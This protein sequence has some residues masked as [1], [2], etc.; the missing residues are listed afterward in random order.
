MAPSRN[1]SKCNECSKYVTNKTGGIQCQG[2]CGF[3]FHFECAGKSKS[4]YRFN[5]GEKS[6][7]TCSKCDKD[8]EEVTAVTE[9]KACHIGNSDND[10][11][12]Q[13][14]L[15]IKILT[16]QI[17]EISKNQCD[18]RNQ[19]TQLQNENAILIEALVTFERNQVSCADKLKPNAVK[20]NI[21]S[22]SMSLNDSIGSNLSNG[23]LRPDNSLVLTSAV[24]NLPS[25][26]NNGSEGD[27]QIP[28][29]TAVYLMS[30]SKFTKRSV[31][32]K[33][34]TKKKSTPQ[35]K[36]ASSA[37]VLEGKKS[38][39]S[40][41]TGSTDVKGKPRAGFVEV[42]YKK[43]KQPRLSGFIIGRTNSDDKLKVVDKLRYLFVSRI[44]EQVDSDSLK[45]YINKQVEGNFEITKLRSK[46]PGYSSYK[47]GVPISLWE[48]IFSPDF[49]PSGAF[50]NRFRYN[51]KNFSSGSD[52]SHSFLEQGD[53]TDPRS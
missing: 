5:T 39:F 25:D 34:T 18:M 48:K 43:R 6:N 4:E 7:F 35:Q 42:R 53:Q 16:D 47:V 9:S 17:Y 11:C 45:Q 8:P 36:P 3:W 32:K 50:V 52:F 37:L 23:R 41:E 26:G 29:T 46:R 38:R 20:Q 10:D 12:S 33:S 40:S 30:D 51:R 27:C 2:N 21:H 13:C 28:K 49:W 31:N 15:H 24:S 19:L 14:N 1:S 22:Q 44:A